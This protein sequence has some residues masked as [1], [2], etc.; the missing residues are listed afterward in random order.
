MQ[1]KEVVTDEGELNCAEL[2]KLKPKFHLKALQ[3]LIALG[4]FVGEVLEHV[5]CTE[6]RLLKVL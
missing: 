2:Y 6:A 5:V 4:L 1:S 3:S